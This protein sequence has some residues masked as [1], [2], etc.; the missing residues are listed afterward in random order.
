M[1]TYCDIHE[2]ITI[3]N[4]C[5]QAKILIAALR[6]YVRK[7]ILSLDW[8]E[9]NSGNLQLDDGRG[10]VRLSGSVLMDKAGTNRIIPPP[11]EGEEFGEARY[12]LYGPLM[13]ALDS[14]DT[15]DRIVFEWDGFVYRAY[16][17]GRYYWP[18][19]LETVG[20]TTCVDYRVIQCEEG[21]HMPT[22]KRTNRLGELVDVPFDKPL[23]ALP[24]GL[25]FETYSKLYIGIN[26]DHPMLW[27][28]F[29]RETEAL[30][31]SL[32]ASSGICFDYER[33]EG[34]LYLNMESFEWTRDTVEGNIKAM[35]P[36]I[37]IGLKDSCDV[38][39][40]AIFLPGGRI[41]DFS[42]FAALYLHYQRGRVFASACS[43][44]D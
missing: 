13:A 3:R 27:D 41:G 43:F 22:V 37:D 19:V 9:F 30:I 33:E 14:L 11:P 6:E 38:D 28:R 4:D 40:E 25:K 26:D 12:A 16:G 44:D 42:P 34:N 31:R 39:F 36:F 20:L 21:E 23:T 5:G 35:Q 10:A 2:R 24:A 17:L 15:A 1:G 32:S 8:R 29:D 7:V 18:G